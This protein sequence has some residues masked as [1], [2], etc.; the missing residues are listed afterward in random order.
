MDTPNFIFVMQAEILQKTI[1]I[2]SIPSLFKKKASVFSLSQ[3][4]SC[5]HLHI[6]IRQQS[7]FSLNSTIRS[8]LSSGQ[9][10]SALKHFLESQG[11]GLRP[12]KFTIPSLLKLS[13]DLD[14]PLHHGEQI[15]AFSIK[16]GYINDLFVCTGLVE[17]YFKNGQF[18]A[19]HQLFGEISKRDV[20]LFTA[21]IC[22]FSQNG[23]GGEALYF[24]SE[25]LEEGM[26][27]NSITMST[28]LSACSR[29][30]EYTLGRILHGAS[31]RS[32]LLEKADMI[33]ETALL[34]MYAKCGNLCHAKRIFDRMSERNLI[35]WNSIINAYILNGS[36]ELALALFK[37][38]ILEGWRHPRSSTIAA[39]LNICR[40][41]TDL[42]KGKEIHG[43][44]L[45]CIGNS[46]ELEC[47]IM[48][49][50]IIDMYVKTGDMESAISLFRG[51]AKRNVV[52]WT[53]MIAGYG[54]HGL[55]RKALE[56]F[57]DMKKS[58]IRPD[59]VS[60]VSILSACSHGGL[61]DEGQQ[62]YHSMQ[63][64]YNIVPEMM[65]F[66]CM[67]D[68]Y[69]RAGLLDKA[70]DFIKTMPVEPSKIVWGSLLSSCRNHKNLEL[71]E[72]AAKKALE[73][74]QYDVG[75]YLLLSR[76][77][78]DTRRWEDFAK[79]RSLMKEVGLRA[80]TACSW[81]ELRGKV[82][83]FT[84]GDRL[85]TC[86]EKIYEFLETLG[87]I[88]ENA[89][90]VRDSSNVGHKINEEEKVS[91]LCG[92]TEKLALGFV[93]MHF[94]GERLIRIGKNL[95]VCR[96]CHEAFKFISLIYYR[97]IILKDPNR[98]HRFVQGR[99]SC[100]DFW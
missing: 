89:G 41:T 32:G 74:D 58:G 98:Y 66:V 29:L 75:N 34:D 71:G 62:L 6:N 64:D 26:R 48:Y 35:S 45:K 20:V 24:F 31:L 50:A 27:P 43:Y 93:L 30:R 49:N 88:M 42:R 54:A 13:L 69:G 84:V 82:Y 57:N 51:T 8:H 12:D 68:L 85:K 63:Q 55:S 28:A 47:S 37:D 73:L 9:P 67:V 36:F 25:M 92:H 38:M 87:L 4:F 100:Y 70:H 14:E 2:K 46:S 78:A 59:G 22:G 86:S 95:R 65:H 11:Q 90:F 60:F 61:V 44:V 10:E 80:T 79:V 40:V 94:Q 19:P 1:P 23:F 99:C 81:V 83:R 91:D 52:S 16:S 72:S 3:F 33:L 5:F 21:M 53:I 18:N 96:D 76:L 97:E 77:Y 15:H 17:M 39:V 7:T 56:T